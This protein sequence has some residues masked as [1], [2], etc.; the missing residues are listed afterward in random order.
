MYAASGILILQKRIIALLYLE[1][2]IIL[3]KS[4][5]LCVVV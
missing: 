1:Y 2:V 4:K 3:L 5:Q